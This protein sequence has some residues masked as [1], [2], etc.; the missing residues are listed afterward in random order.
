MQ[1]PLVLQGTTQAG[2]QPALD[3]AVGAAAQ[4]QTPPAAP[5]AS[6]LIDFLQLKLQSLTNL[7]SMPWW[8]ESLAILVITI[9]VAMGTRFLLCRVLRKLALRT[10]LHIDDSLIDLMRRPLFSSILVLGVALALK[11]LQLNA[12]AIDRSFIT[13]A[14]I[15]WIPFSFKACSLLLSAASEDDIIFRAVEPRT[16]PLF[17]NLTKVLLFSGLTYVIFSRI[18]NI[19][20]AG[21]LVSAGIAGIAIGF[22]AQDTLSNLFA[23]VFIIADTPYAVGD[24][25]NLDSGER[26]RVLH[27]GL[28]STRMLTRD[29][30]QI[31]IPNAIMG[32]AKITNETGGPSPKHRIRVG[33][34][35]AYGSDIDRVR[36]ILVGVAASESNVCKSPEPRVRFRNFGDSGLDFELCCWIDQPV[37]R[38]RV[39]DA[40]NSKV[41]KAFNREEIE[42]PYPKQDV[43]MHHV[44]P[45]PGDAS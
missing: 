29:D 38:G 25:I 39:L 43:Y 35:C 2:S 41:Y 14:V 32:Q 11:P 1:I 31:T 4:A 10:R 37:L 23:G 5:D 22:A 30:I 36:E 20:P 24:F 40:L 19:D 26:G 45:E 44:T 15:I 8:F 27:I 21:F 9:L 28:R 42:I 34:S 7:Q 13:L 17:D 12:A 3:A 6:D 16:F 18:W 33:I